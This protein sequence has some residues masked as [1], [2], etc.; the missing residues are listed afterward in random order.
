MES[1]VGGPTALSAA[2][3]PIRPFS[4][5]SPEIFFAVD[6]VETLDS[7]ALHV[8][9]HGMG[10]VENSY[11]LHPDTLSPMTG[12]VENA[13]SVLVE[14]DLSRS[15]RG[16]SQCNGTMESIESQGCVQQH[17]EPECVSTSS[18]AARDDTR[19][20][21]ASDGVASAGRRAPTRKGVPEAQGEMMLHILLQACDSTSC[22]CITFVVLL[23]FM[24]T[25]LH[26]RQRIVTQRGSH[27]APV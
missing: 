19:N 16:E 26:H 22:P 17:V 5:E 25:R 12:D 18:A 6:S 27:G 10:P 14:S 24:N 4:R 23:L 11:L 2:S 13:D 3:S 15:T 8:T 1:H 20:F 7:P 9:Y 21:I